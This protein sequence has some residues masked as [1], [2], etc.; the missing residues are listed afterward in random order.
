MVDVGRE[1]PS[2][3]AEGD[4]EGVDAH[5]DE[6]PCSVDEFIRVLPEPDEQVGR[7]LVPAEDPD[8]LPPGRAV[9]GHGHA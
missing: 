9:L 3:R 4:D 2:E 8:R 6:L 7:D 1:G 5:V